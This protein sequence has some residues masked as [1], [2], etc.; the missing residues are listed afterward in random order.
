MAN[1]AETRLDVRTIEADEATELYV[2]ASPP[3][4]VAVAPASFW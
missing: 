2:T 4:G 3:S 1:E